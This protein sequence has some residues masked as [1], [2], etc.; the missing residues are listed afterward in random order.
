M[1][2]H[3]ADVMQFQNKDG[4]MDR[5]LKYH[6]ENNCDLLFVDAAHKGKSRLYQ[7][8]EYGKLMQRLGS[9]IFVHDFPGHIAYGE[10]VNSLAAVGFIYRYHHVITKTKST[11]GIFERIVSSSNSNYAS[12]VVLK[13][14]CDEEA[15]KALC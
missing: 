14:F 15:E 13:Q 1:S 5:T 3:I 12:Q 7:A 11:V 4:V 9:I 6:V 2:F 10:W 8:T